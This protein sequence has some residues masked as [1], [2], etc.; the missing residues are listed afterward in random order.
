VPKRPQ[1]LTDREIKALKPKDKEY[2]TCIDDNLYILTTPHGVKRWLFIFLDR[3][4]KKRYKMT[5]GTYPFLALAKARSEALR[6]KALVLEGINPALE[7]KEAKATQNQNRQNTLENVVSIFLEHKQKS[8]RNSWSSSHAKKM[9]ERIYNNLSPLYQKPF[10]SISRDDLIGIFN[11]KIEKN[12]LELANRLYSLFREIWTFA[13]GRGFASV[14]IIDAID[15]NSYIPLADNKNFYFIKEPKAF[16]RLLKD[17]E[18]YGGYLAR[19]ALKL[20][21]HLAL[22]PGNLISIRWEWIDFKEKTLLIPSERM[23]TRK[24]FLVPLTSQALAIIEGL[25]ILSGDKP[26]IFHSDT[27]KSGHITDV[28]LLQALESLG[29][30]NIHNP[31]GFRHTFSTLCHENIDRH[32]FESRIIEMCLSHTD[33]NKIRAVYNKADRLSERRALMEWWSSYIDVLKGG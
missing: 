32:G 26:C 2:T 18:S 19:E 24:D 13:V 4:T 5:L 7:K 29:Y 16:G 10:A 3:E 30:K 31:H 22:R 1:R 11:A 25:K 23:K 20:Q 9:Q 28:S 27:A 14:N 21:S 6:L 15:K 12:H 33:R 17:L 8:Q